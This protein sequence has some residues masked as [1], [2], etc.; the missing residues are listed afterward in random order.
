[1]MD[2]SPVPRPDLSVV[3]A[4][5]ESARSIER[6]VRSVRTALEGTRSE[7]LVV[8]ASR[9]Q[10]AELAERQLGKARVVRCTSGTLTPE[11]WAIGIARSTGSIVA[12]T[13]GH[14]VVEQTWAASLMAAVNGGH[15]GAAGFMDLGDDATATDSAVFYLRY[16]GFIADGQ[17]AREGVTGIPADNAAY[18]GD[19]ARRFVA[20]TGDGF[21]EVDF[22]RQI[23]AHGGTLATVAGATASYCRS[24]PLRTIANHRFQ[25]G[26]HA[27][28]WRVSQRERS[29]PAMVA[30]APLVPFVLA[31]R[32]WRHLR[33]G[34]S[35]RRRFVAALPAFLLLAGAW[36][37]GEAVGALSG[38]PA[39]RHPIPATA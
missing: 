3:I 26:R 31:A 11:L 10:S 35:H 29:I 2:K 39:V 20:A 37:I 36:A 25:H 34:T 9:D 33:P 7:L 28:A 21:W 12:L 13:T 38:P 23:H 27:G 5:V 8:D 1:M 18:D 19:A 22:H 32:A 24:F 16:N 14:F 17:S 4:S 15:V 6:C 30:A